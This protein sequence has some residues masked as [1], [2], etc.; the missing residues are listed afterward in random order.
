MTKKNWLAVGII[1]GILLLLAVISYFYMTQRKIVQKRVN[2]SVVVYGSTAERWVAF[3]QGVDQAA[4]DFGGIVNFV[5]LTESGS[6]REQ[7][8]QIDRLL[9]KG[10]DVLLVN[11]VD[12]TA[13]AVLIDKAEAAGVPVI[14]FN[15]QPV[16]EDIDY[17]EFDT[18]L[19]QLDSEMRD[20]GKG[21]DLVLWGDCGVCNF[22]IARTD[23]EKLDF[24]RVLY[25]WDCC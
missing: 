5:V 11:I 21:G 16:A 14:F 17:R 23:L 3:K 4:S 25:N 13:A 6:S 10:C 9:S 20:T 22:F 1:G 8:E 19:F 2:I 12:R 24:S 7:M 18:L 15:R